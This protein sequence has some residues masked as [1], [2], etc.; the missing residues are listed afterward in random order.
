MVASENGAISLLLTASLLK[1]RMFCQTLHA[2][3]RVLGRV[4][5]FCDI[6]KGLF[7]LLPLSSRDLLLLLTFTFA[8]NL[9]LEIWP[10]DIFVANGQKWSKI[11][12][13]D[14]P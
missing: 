1:Y 6:T 11:T 5:T 4:V 10:R 14:A 3:S 7:P 8:F 13:M 12:N 9:D 2:S